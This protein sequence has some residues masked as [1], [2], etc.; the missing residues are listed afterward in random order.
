MSECLWSGWMCYSGVKTMSPF[1]C[2]PV[3]REFLWEEN[4]NRKNIC[5]MLNVFVIT[6]TIDFKENKLFVCLSACLS[7]SLLIRTLIVLDFFSLFMPIFTSFQVHCPVLI[8]GLKSTLCRFE[9]TFKSIISN[10]E[11]RTSIKI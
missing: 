1:R 3:I 10:F 6:S 11:F 4:P 7:I 5:I 9:I 8:Q 2:S